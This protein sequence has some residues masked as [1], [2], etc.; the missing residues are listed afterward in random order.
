MPKKAKDLKPKIKTALFLE[1]EQIEWLKSL[2]R[3]FPGVAMSDHVRRAINVY[4]RE[5]EKF[6][7]PTP[8]GVEER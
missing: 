8:P 7:T 1:V 4:R 2:T 5:V 6:K 3:K